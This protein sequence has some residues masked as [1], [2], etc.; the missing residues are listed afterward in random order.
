MLRWLAGQGFCTYLFDWGQPTKDAG[1][2]TFDKAVGER[3]IPALLSIGGPCHLL[4]YCMGGL[5]AASVSTL[6]P[7][8]VKSLLLLATPWNFHDAL[9][10]MRARISLMK[11]MAIPHMKQH[12][13][14]PESWMQ[15]VFATLDPESSI[16]KFA[17]FAAMDDADMRAQIFVAVEDWL[18]EGVDL[19]SAIAMSCM[20]EWYEDNKPAQGRWKV[21]EMVIKAADI[22]V[23][24]MVVAASQDKIVPLESAIAF[25]DQ[26]LKGDRLVCNTGHIGLIAGG[27]V[28]EE[29]WKPSAHWFAS[30]Q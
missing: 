4:G 8:L 23:P 2:A 13:L 15:A 27:K 18:N 6:R 16:R 1:Q 11:P 12:N 29:V 22:R 14:L 17:N 21:C 24:T 10:A 20:E 30:Q 7:D 26:R 25:A 3:L 5:M 28:V 19:P 9:G